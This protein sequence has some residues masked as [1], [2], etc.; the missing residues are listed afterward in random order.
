MESSY[1]PLPNRPGSLIYFRTKSPWG[2]PYFNR[3]SYFFGDIFP[4][5]SLIMTGLLICF[6]D[7]EAACFEK[8]AF[9][10]GCLWIWY[11]KGGC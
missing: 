5:G 9:K 6:S 10:G 1:F 4:M 2:P 8:E 11:K 7:V 3:V